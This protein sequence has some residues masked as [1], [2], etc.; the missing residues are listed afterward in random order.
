MP[1]RV[2]SFQG[3]KLSQIHRNFKCKFHRENCIG[4]CD[5]PKI[6]WRMLSRMT[7]RPWIHKS[8]P[9]TKLD[10][11]NVCCHH[12]CTTH[13]PAH[14]SSLCVVA[15]KQHNILVRVNNICCLVWFV[16]CVQPL[17]HTSLRVP[18]AC[19]D[20]SG[21]LTNKTQQVSITSPDIITSY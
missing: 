4:G 12:A 2:I 14:Y 18:I 15:T 5:M 20:I 17:H 7:I 11:K 1:Y 8:L 10:F 16:V 3:R 9:V 13:I 19:H 6:S 21:K